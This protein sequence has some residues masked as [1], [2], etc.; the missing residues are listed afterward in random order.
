MLNPFGSYW[1]RQYHYQTA[2]TH[3]GNLLAT[4]FSAADHIRPYAPSYNGR[5]QKFSLLIAPYS[6]DVPP[7]SIR[8]DAEAFAYPYVVLNDDGFM[9]TPA[10]RSWD[11]AGLGEIP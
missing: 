11:G 7:E 10:H 8:F 2:D 9:D 4:T 5:I 1:G 3:L 6:G